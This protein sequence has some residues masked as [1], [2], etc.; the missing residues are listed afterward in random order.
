MNILDKIKKMISNVFKSESS[1]NSD[2]EKMQAEVDEQRFK[3]KNAITE[4]YFQHEKLTDEKANLEN[5]AEKVSND[6]R[7]SLDE[8]RDDLS[9]HLIE[10]SDSIKDQVTFINEQLEQIEINLQSAKESLKELDENSFKIKS[11]ISNLESK[12][13]VLESQKNIKEQISS[14]NGNLNVSY[15]NK[16]SQ[17]IHKLNAQIKTIEEKNPLEK[18]LN[19][20]RQKSIERERIK[21]LEQLKSNYFQKEVIVK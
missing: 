15:T 14:L 17:Q 9:L 7:L 21:K 4:L 12:R 10:K 20:L 13:K 8:N 16:L 1:F 3:L 6:L 5:E 2:V 18:D 11:K 19:N